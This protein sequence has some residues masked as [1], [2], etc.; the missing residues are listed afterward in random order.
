MS[1]VVYRESWFRTL[2]EEYGPLVTMK[3]DAKNLMVCY[4]YLSDYR[5]RGHVVKYQLYCE[6]GKKG[7]RER[8]VSVIKVCQGTTVSEVWLNYNKVEDYMR[9]EIDTYIRENRLDKD[10]YVQLGKLFTDDS[11][12]EWP[13]LH[14]KHKR[15][16]MT[17]DSDGDISIIS[18][19]GMG[20]PLPNMRFRWNGGYEVITDTIELYN[21]NMDLI[22]NYLKAVEETN[23]LVIRDVFT[24]I[25]QKIK[26]ISEKEEE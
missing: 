17:L 20:K 5:S 1:K 25:E 4:L 23:N 11:V 6:S 26:E 9:N 24:V 22:D 16:T 12:I 18:K 8:R 3:V 13:V 21:R 2:I 14:Y 10:W 19:V 15:Y 7:V